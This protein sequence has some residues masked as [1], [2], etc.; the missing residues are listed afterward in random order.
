M[1]PALIPRLFWRRNLLKQQLRSRVGELVAK[2]E[3]GKELEPDELAHA[4][5]LRELIDLEST[6]AG[7]RRHVI[8]AAI[9]GMALIGNFLLMRVSSVEVEGVVRGSSVELV[10]DRV[11]V[12]ERD[13]PVD[14]L[15]A[16]RYTRASSHPAT[17]GTSL[18]AAPLP[19]GTLTM[20]QITM[21]AG[22]RLRVAS[23]GRGRMLLRVDPQPD[24]GRVRF[25]SRG[26][27]R[28]ATGADTLLLG[29]GE[30][31]VLEFGAERFNLQFAPTTSA[32]DLLT[33]VPALSL[34]FSES[35]VRADGARQENL[36]I[37]SIDAGELVLPEMREQKVTLRPHEHLGLRTR[38]L[39]IHRLRSDSGGITV[40][41]RARASRLTLGEGGAERDLRPSRLEWLAA[42]RRLELAR[43]TFVAAIGMLLSLFAWWKR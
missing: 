33:G 1:D 31:L 13:I 7:R 43:V 18:S 10:M 4:Q 25:T 42:N 15:W 23:A 30:A 11:R 20:E 3:N 34:S 12:L 28:V 36:E 21:P 38:T 19:G 5:A 37:S 8:F 35:R 16:A 9:A 29:S 26:G 2:A 27:A 40:E 39:R 22:A 6:V 41:F 14:S 24:T 32:V 17:A